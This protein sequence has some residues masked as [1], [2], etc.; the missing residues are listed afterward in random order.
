MNTV[1][2]R[3][4]RDVDVPIDQYFGVERS[5]YGED[6]PNK[7]AQVVRAQI[8]FPDLYQTTTC[9]DCGPDVLQLE[10]QLIRE[11]FL[12]REAGFPIG[13]QVNERALRR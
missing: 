9:F 1:G 11:V 7:S 6:L 12:S 13:D 3:Y 8:A 10:P 5:R 2:T 4:Q